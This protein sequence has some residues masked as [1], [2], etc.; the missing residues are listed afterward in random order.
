MSHAKGVR[1][2][3]KARQELERQGYICEQKNWSRC[4]GKDFWNTFDIIGLRMGEVI[5][6]QVKTNE[7]HKK[8]VLAHF[9]AIV[10]HIPA[11]WKCEVWIWRDRKGWKFHNLRYWNE[12]AKTL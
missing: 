3:K 11:S 9:N 5:A 7:S 1:T 4:A 12:K 2:E 8:A 10:G 6:V